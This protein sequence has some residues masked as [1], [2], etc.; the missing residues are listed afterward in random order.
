MRRNTGKLI[1]LFLAVVLAGA[2]AVMLTGRNRKEGDGTAVLSRTA[3][4]ETEPVYTPA[5]PDP[6]APDKKESVHVSADA[7]GRPLEITVETTLKNPGGNLEPIPDASALKDIRNREGDEEYTV[8]DGILLWENHGEDILYEGTFDGELPVTVEIRSWLDGEELPPAGLAGKSG[9]VKLR[10]DYHNRTSETVIVKE[11]E[12]RVPVPFLA[13]TAMFLP[14]DTFRNLSVTNGKKLEM[15]DRNVV[16]GCAMPGLASVLHL[17]A[18]EV[19]EEIEIPEYVEVEADVTDFAL[20]FTA[21][22]LTNRLLE[23]L[24]EK[25][26]SEIDD[27][28]DGMDDLKEA[29]DELADGT[30]ELADGLRDFQDIL[31]QYHDGVKGVSDGAAALNKGL[32]TLSRNKGALL[33]GAKALEGSLKQLA[34]GMDLSIPG[35]S[36]EEVKEITSTLDGLVKNGKKLQK[37]LEEAGVGKEQWEALSKEAEAYAQAMKKA[38]KKARKDLKKVDLSELE[39]SMN[40]K[41][42]SQAEAALDKV[43][44]D[45]DLTEKQKKKIKKKIRKSIDIHGMSDEADACLRV[46]LSDLDSL[47]ELSLPE[48][49]FDDKG[50]RKLIG[51]MEKQVKSLASHTDTYGKI[52]DQLLTLDATVQTVKAGFMALADG[53]TGLRKGIQAFNKGID[54]LTKGSSELKAGAAE[55][56]D[57]GGELADGLDEVIDAVEEMSEGIGE[58]RDEGVKDLSDLAGDDLQRIVDTLR[59]LQKADLRYENYGGILAGKTGEVRFLIETEEIEK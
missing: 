12:Y 59:A 39:E 34:Q 33:K 5:V 4:R 40:K 37:K 8:Q 15:D 44:G 29:V 20:D 57:A 41:A 13:I 11:A 25:D 30:G 42:R 3:E 18:W 6:E 19:T 10:F 24:E 31:R 26:L 7:A 54:Q 9:H 45:M 16:I 48:A 49:D 56:A 38:V 47:P 17:S 22:I 2:A 46:A 53:A 32:K 14:S 52:F 21:T 23:E 36:E 27:M 28:V 51:K 43:L 58:F 1:L 55:L 35:V 50:L